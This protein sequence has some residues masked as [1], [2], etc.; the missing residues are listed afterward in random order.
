MK[1]IPSLCRHHYFSSVSIFSATLLLVVR[2]VGCDTTDIT[3][4][5]E[6]QDWKDLNDIRDNPDGRFPD[7][8]AA[9][10]IGPR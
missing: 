1:A 8:A 3:Q 6:I 9:Q 7:T 10:T 5:F 2:I 4:P